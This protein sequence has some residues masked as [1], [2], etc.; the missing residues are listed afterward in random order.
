MQSVMYRSAHLGPRGTLLCE[1]TAHKGPIKMLHS[2]AVRYMRSDTPYR[3]ARNLA[4]RRKVE[5]KKWGSAFFFETVEPKLRKL[6][7]ITH[8]VRHHHSPRHP[9]FEWRVGIDKITLF[10]STFFRFFTSTNTN[11]IPATI[12]T[13]R[14]KNVRAVSIGQQRTDY[15]VR[16]EQVGPVCG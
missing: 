3:C 14:K 11:Y 6:R 2:D 10:F 8:L 5:M 12:C 4:G 9:K 15:C 7:H 1:N 16:R 13:D